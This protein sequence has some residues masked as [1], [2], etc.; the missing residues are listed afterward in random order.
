MLLHKNKIIILLLVTVAYFSLAYASELLFTPTHTFFTIRLAPAFGLIAALVYGLPALIGV[1]LGEFL[2]FYILHHSEIT[3]PVSI[4]LAAIAVLYAYIGIRLIQRYIELPNPLTSSSDCFKFFTLAGA[5]ASLVPSLLAVYC[6]SLTEPAVQQSFWLL[7]THWWLGQVLGVFIIS[8]IILCFAWK[9][10]PEWQARIPL[11]PVLM[12]TLL[13]II[14]ITYAYVS[15][16]EEEKLKSVLEQKSLA[17]SSAIKIKMSNYEEALYSIKSLFEYTPDINP[18]EFEAFNNKIKTRHPGVHA[19]SFQPLVKAH[20]REVYESRMRELYSNNFQITERDDSGIF[21]RA[22]ERE[23]YTP[24][25]MRSV[26]DKKARIMGFDTSTSKQSTLARQQAK[27]T[28]TLA[29]SRAFKLASTAD[30]SKS[31]VL[32]LSLDRNGLF[33]GYV[34]MSVYAVK[35]IQSAIESVDME[36]IA[37]KVWDDGPSENNLIYSKDILTQENGTALSNSGKIKF[38]THDWVYE[39]VPESTFLTPLVTSQLLTIIFCILLSSIISLRLLEHTGKRLELNRRVLESE[40]QIR[41]LLDSTAEAIYGI[42]LNGNCTFCNAACIKILGYEN[43]DALLGNN[44]HELIH[45]SHVDGTPYPIEE[46]PIYEAFKRSESI[47]VDDEVLWRADRSSFAAEYWSYPIF[48]EEKLVGS[49]ATFLDITERKRAEDAL[50]ESEQYNRMLFQ[51]SSIGLHLCRMDGQMVDVNPAYA[52]IIGRTVEE[53]LQLSYWDVTPKKYAEQEQA[54]LESLEKTGKYGPYEK[55]YIHADGHLVPVRLS[56]HILEKDGEKFIWSGAEDITEQKH[57]EDEL[58]NHQDHLEELVEERTEELVTQK[59]ILEKTMNNI[60]QG[61][62]MYDKNQRLL[63]VNAKYAD[64]VSMPDNEVKNATSYDELLTY[65]YDV[66]LKQPELLNQ[67]IEQAKSK[68]P[69]CYLVNFP[70]GKVVEINHFPVKDGG[71]VRTFTDV[72]NRKKAEQE[73]RYAREVAETANQTKSTFLANMSHELRTPLNAVLG[74]SELMARD[75]AVSK[76]QI[77][78][79]ETINRSGKH[80]L[81]L[82]NDVLDMSKIEA[83]HIKLHPEPVNLPLLLN[84]IN[85]LFSQRA[86]T[87]SIQFSVELSPDLPEH[88]LLDMGKLQQVLI[89]LLGNAMNFTRAG[90]VILRVG[91]AEADMGQCSLSFEVEDTGTG[92]PADEIENIFEPFTQT[93]H[94]GSE[95]KGAGLGLAICHQ[96]IQLMSGEINVESTLGKGTVFHFEIPTEL[97]DASQTN[98]PVRKN[99]RQVVGLATD[100]PEWRILIVEDAADNRLLLFRLLESIGFSLRVATNG[101]EAIQQ[102]QDW[103]PHLIWMDMRMPV[104]DGYEATRHIRQLPGGKEIK[105][106]GLTASAFKDQEK[107]C[108]AVGCDAVLHKPFNMTEIFNA[109][110]EQLGLQYSYEEVSNSLD[111]K[112]ETLCVDDLAKLQKQW[113]DELLSAARLGDTEAMLSLTE[114]LDAEHAETKAKLVHFIK[115]FQIEALINILKE[116]TTNINE[117]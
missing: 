17:M 113:M 89:N 82:I 40:E 16:H 28:K 69:L 58:K 112:T 60:A 104:M 33:S 67:V 78:T 92:I 72:T 61:I 32:Y 96:F 63:A 105:I 43:Q 31:V 44:M 65:S 64:I 48:Q 26:Y 51:E 117:A 54:Q 14:V 53:T 85:D 111:Q 99:Q 62:V 20:E 41:L 25:T 21:K 18:Q 36:G 102:F 45:H 86:E 38:I 29:I 87:K 10:I 98:Q 39:L 97:A 46:C 23:E 55:E 94:S 4:T 83:G 2:Y 95:Q 68:E 77:E 12:T 19:S 100:E 107:Q 76:K 35:V 37:I 8:P 115:E 30:N 66:V 27:S 57:A 106:L 103:Q 74:F 22:S 116:H 81:G 93:S 101:M 3:I 59:S 24:I 91:R 90:M 80:L 47:H 5:A 79:L 15:V 73:M 84:N 109:M 42:D 56:G 110:A 49:V 50:R 75:P 11:I 34:A 13:A 6:L 88:V 52:R 114:T 71:A 70:D 9:S 108:L 1:F 7:G